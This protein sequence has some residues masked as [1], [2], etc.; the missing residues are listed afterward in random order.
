M[1]RIGWAWAAGLVGLWASGVGA[2]EEGAAPAPAPVRNFVFVMQGPEQ[3]QLP[4][5]PVV[6]TEK[7]AEAELVAGAGEEGDGDGEEG[8]MS[9]AAVAGLAAGSVAGLA[10]LVALAVLVVIRRR[11]ARAQ[12]ETAEEGGQPP[13][14]FLA[15]LR[16]HQEKR[17]GLQ[18]Q[19][20]RGLAAAAHKSDAAV[21]SRS[22]GKTTEAGRTGSRPAAG[23]GAAGDTETRSE[24]RSSGWESESGTTTEGPESS[25]LTT[26]T[27]TL[28][29]AGATR[30]AV[31]AS[32]ALG[33]S[34]S[35][36]YPEPSPDQ[37]LRSATDQPT[38]QGRSS[39]QSTLPAPTTSST[40]A[41]H[42]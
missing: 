19:R 22:S 1:G 16:K 15:S 37:P 24:T 17:D 18:Y 2:A 14:P 5:A 3:K 41:I 25:V 20:G 13:A 30:P 33:D 36:F 34:D 10:A 9:G 27:T 23:A 32:S 11:R 42:A 7:A 28:A 8:G 21:S 4:P 6:V 12:Q 29:T 35:N 31:G 26:E 39:D 38:S 40:T